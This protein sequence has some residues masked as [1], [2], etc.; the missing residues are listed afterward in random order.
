M[1][2]S[3][4]MKTICEYCVITAIVLIIIAVIIMYNFKYLDHYGGECL[5]NIANTYC[6]ELNFSH[7]KASRDNE[8]FIAGLPKIMCFDYCD[9]L[10]DNTGCYRFTGFR[11]LPEELEG[12]KK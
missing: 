3:K 7:G 2:M 1:G 6:Q 8:G 10:R 12:C 4:K 11:Y 5:E 9:P